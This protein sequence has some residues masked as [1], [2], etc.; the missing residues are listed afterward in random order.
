MRRLKGM[1]LLAAMCAMPVLAQTPSAVPTLFNLD[2]KADLQLDGTLTNI[3]PDATLA[4][5]LQ[6]MV[7]KRV[8]E[9]QYELATW[10]GKPVL[11]A[12]SQRIVVEAVP[13][14]SGG[15]VMRIKQVTP[16][17]ISISPAEMTDDFRMVPPEYPGVVRRRNVVGTLVYAMSIDAQGKAQAVELI[18][19]EQPDRWFKMLDESSRAAIAKWTMPPSRVNGVPV[20][21]RVLIP[22]QFTLSNV[23]MPSATNTKAYRSSHADICPSPPTLLTKVDGS[24]L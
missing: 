7:R 21:C 15:Y 17:T 1:L 16:A 18:F 20:D 2:F 19:P 10:Q 8:E 11:G 22:M 6:A 9:W 23:P 14:S 12:T 4:P 3:Q 13:V 24:L 5:A